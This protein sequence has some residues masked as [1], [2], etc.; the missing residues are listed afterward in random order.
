VRD[1]EAL[2]DYKEKKVIY[3]ETDP[4]EP[5]QSAAPNRFAD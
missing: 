5:C 4:K 3:V 1:S 2:F